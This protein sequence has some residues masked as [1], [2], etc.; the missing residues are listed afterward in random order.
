VPRSCSILIYPRIIQYWY[1]YSI[2][3]HIDVR[4]ILNVF[5]NIK[6]FSLSLLFNFHFDVSQVIRFIHHKDVLAKP[7]FVQYR[8]FRR[9]SPRPPASGQ[10]RV[11]TSETQHILRSGRP[12]TGGGTF[13]VRIWTSSLGA[14]SSTFV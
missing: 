2:I 1:C 4:L 12:W 7:D 6:F 13:G 3:S 9:H 5:C 11:K 8:T 14:P 10:C